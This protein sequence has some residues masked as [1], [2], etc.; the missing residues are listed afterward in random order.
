MAEDKY[1]ESVVFEQEAGT[2]TVAIE[3]QNQG[4]KMLP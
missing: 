2:N 3:R 4:Y 1:N